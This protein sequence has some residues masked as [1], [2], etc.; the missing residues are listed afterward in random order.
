MPPEGS[1]LV[2]SAGCDKAIDCDAVGTACSPRP[3]EPRRA[4][5]PS[6]AKR[7]STA[8][9]T[10]GAVLGRSAGASLRYWGMTSRG[11]SVFQCRVRH[12]QVSPPQRG[13]AC[14]SIRDVAGPSDDEIE[15]MTI[16]GAV[17]HNGPIHLAEYDP[18]WPVLFSRETARGLV[19]RWA[20][21]WRFK[22]TQQVALS[23]PSSP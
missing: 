10:A 14:L 23:R 15:A 20:W 22:F 12:S 9:S 1:S 11:L 6:Y 21:P 8:N 2:K 13:L 4:V 19:A 3:G 16:G 5:W 18:S 17:V 7:L